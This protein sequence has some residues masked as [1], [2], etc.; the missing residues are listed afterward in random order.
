MTKKK[1]LSLEN[2]EV[3][4]QGVP[5]GD[6]AGR[7]ARR[8]DVSTSTVTREVKANRTIREKK[9][10][11]KSKPS[12]RCANYQ[13]CQ[14]SG[15][16]CKK[17][18]TRLTT[19]K[20]CKTRSCIAS[21]PDFK[22]K[23][24]PDTERW[25]YVCPEKCSKRAY[26]G[27]PKCSYDAEAA[28]ANYRVRLASSREGIDMSDEQLLSLDKIVTPLVKQGHSFEAICFTHEEVGV[29]ARTLYNYQDKGL[30]STANIELPR[31]VRLKPRKKN[32]HAGRDRV[33]RAGRTYDDFLALPLEE[34]VRVVQGDSVCGYE[35][36]EHD[37]LSLHMVAYAFQFYLRKRHADSEAVVKWL[38]VIERALGSR[39]AFK[40]IFPVLLLDRGVE[41][42]DWEGM[43]RS[44][45]EFGRRRCRVFYCD[46]MES[47][48][49]SQ[50]ER[51]HEQLRR[52]LPKERTDF[53][54][55]SVYDIATCCSH[56][57]SYPIAGRGGKC[58]FELAASILPVALL[59][60]LGIARVPTNE[61]ILKPY[62][63]KHAVEQ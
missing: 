1:H 52:I 49:K 9:S 60:E 59:D 34:Q 62:L 8:I 3:I 43:E 39:E 4:A 35:W 21:C 2:R 53:D 38:D 16:A 30:L 47:N 36:N 54:A 14:K 57:N 48:Q 20:H 27:F 17:C 11:G 19:C 56:V 24:C 41:F 23:M 44:C 12:I 7:I 33:D 32:S 15:S 29:C 51:N 25:P 13:D 5:A 63:M 18:S 55:L 61:V 28:D 22:R 40:A 37:V 46:A 50:A 58:A 26:C 10:T 45:L 6:S 42:D 31:K